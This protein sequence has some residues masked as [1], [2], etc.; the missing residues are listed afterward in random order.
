MLIYDCHELLQRKRYM[1]CIINLCQAYEMFFSLFLRVK[2]LY[3]PFG[4][5]LNRGSNT[6]K[7]MNELRHDLET[8]IGRFT[9]EKMRS[10]FLRLVIESNPPATLH[11]AGKYISELSPMLPKDS[12]VKSVTD[13]SLVDYLMRV[14]GTHINKLR[15]KVVH[16][17]GYRP[18]REEAEKELQEAGSVLFP[19]TR[20]LNLRDDVNLYMR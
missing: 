18:T 15:N 4:H 10:V 19:L 7:F 13:R 8:K 9:F 1:Y 14:K 3:E 6:L 17:A 12:E 11:E 5:S 16:K 20:R 2:L